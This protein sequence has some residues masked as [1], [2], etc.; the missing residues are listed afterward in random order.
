MT[1]SSFPFPPGRGLAP[2]QPWTESLPR[3]AGVREI[4]SDRFPL[5]AQSPNAGRRTPRRGNL[6]E[7]VLTRKP[8]K[9]TDSQSDTTV[10][11]IIK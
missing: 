6:E 9:S 2:A 4:T 3:Q 7:G 8:P 1:T 11:E 10:L 5:R